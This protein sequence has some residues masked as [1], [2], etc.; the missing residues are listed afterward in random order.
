MTC[1]TVQYYAEGCTVHMHG[2]YVCMYV[3]YKRS[4]LSLSSAVIH[5]LILTHKYGNT[6]WCSFIANDLVIS[7]LVSTRATETHY[8]RIC[9]MYCLLI[10]TNYY[11]PICVMYCLLITTNYYLPIC[12]MYC[13]LITTNYYLRICVMYCLLITT[14]YYLPICVMYRVFP[15]CLLIV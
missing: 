6:V 12:V 9:V 11:L 7:W 8:L 14:N 13:L 1:C 15:A 2:M 5:Q 3:Q 4:M 10:T